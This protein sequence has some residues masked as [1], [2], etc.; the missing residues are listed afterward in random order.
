MILEPLHREKL[1][2]GYRYLKLYF[3]LISIYSIYT[4]GRIQTLKR[5]DNKI[6]CQQ[7]WREIDKM[8]LQWAWREM[9]EI[10]LKRA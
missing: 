8:V 7:A 9:E 3:L 4:V 2:W 6:D 5:R 1:V 10:E